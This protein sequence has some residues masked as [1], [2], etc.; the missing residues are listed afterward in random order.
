MVISQ[1]GQLLH[2]EKLRKEVH[3]QPEGLCFDQDGTLYIA[4]EGKGA[5]GRILRFDYHQQ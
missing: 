2:I 4:N 5:K 1:E 3:A